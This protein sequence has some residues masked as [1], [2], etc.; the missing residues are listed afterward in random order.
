L[1]NKKRTQIGATVDS[2][3]YQ[4][5]QILALKT[6]KRHGELL[7]KAI[8]DFIDNYRQWPDDNDNEKGGLKDAD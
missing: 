6:K 4:E 5:L 8:R 3:L 1:S 7:D 2:S